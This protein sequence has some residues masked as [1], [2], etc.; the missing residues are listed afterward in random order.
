MDHVCKSFK[1]AIIFPMMGRNTN[2]VNLQNG[3][4]NMNNL[5]FMVHVPRF[6][7]Y[8]F[9]DSKTNWD[10]RVRYM[11]LAIGERQQH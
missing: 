10:G 8:L 6:D 7:E 1:C 3:L 2:L 5:A 4:E 9:A 11:Q